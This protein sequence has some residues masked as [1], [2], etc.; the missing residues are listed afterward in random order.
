MVVKISLASEMN[1]TLDERHFLIR[2]YVSIK[3]EL[4]AASGIDK[5][6]L[7]Q[8]HPFCDVAN[9]LIDTIGEQK[10]RFL[11]S[12][13][14]RL[15]VSEF[16]KIGYN[17]KLNY[18]SLDGFFKSLK[19]SVSDTAPEQLLQL[20]ALK[21]GEKDKSE[22]K[23]LQ[24]YYNTPA[25]KETFTLQTTA[26]DKNTL[27]DLKISGPLLHKPGVYY[28]KNERDEV[29]Y[30]GKGKRLK[31]RL[32]SHFSHA[33]NHPL[34]DEVHAIDIEY[35]GSDLI[36]QLLESQEIKHLRPKFNSQQVKTPA[37][38]E[39]VIKEN[40]AGVKR[41]VLERKTYQDTESELYYNRNSAKAR[42]AALCK[43]YALCPKYCSLE[44]KAGPCTGSTMG[45]CRGVCTHHE[46]I[47]IYNDRVKMA[48][49]ALKHDVDHKI[50]K[51]NGRK[52]GE[53]GFVLIA[54]GIYQGF[55][56]YS[57]EDTIDTINDLEPYV[58]NYPNN[59]D[60]TRIIDI[61]LKKTSKDQVL[62]IPGRL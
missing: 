46:S 39:I 5:S 37:P 23:L 12:Y 2:P 7:L 51:V 31:K 25:K 38:Y 16:K 33:G 49:K 40:K 14:Y 57:L 26:L 41:F 52:R 8:A 28:F 30:V 17:C 24:Q 6:Q 13:Q 48:Q 19:I 10:A 21:M 29:I 18:Q 53:S 32:Q 43:N 56:F 42:L 35:T 9:E 34:Y 50:I 59:Y 4:L 27:A 55:G 58:H 45:T 3:K 61:F 22:L 20:L 60:T 44:R 54:N 1:G 62:D 36:A 47:D 15:F 11:T